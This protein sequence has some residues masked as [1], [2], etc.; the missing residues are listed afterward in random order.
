VCDEH[1]SVGSTTSQTSP[2]SANLTS[3]GDHNDL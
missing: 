1:V 3:D 2:L